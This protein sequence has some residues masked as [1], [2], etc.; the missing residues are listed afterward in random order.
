MKKFWQFS[1]F[2]VVMII[3]IFGIYSS[4]AFAQSRSQNITPI[5]KDNQPVVS[6]SQKVPETDVLAENETIVVSASPMIEVQPSSD[7]LLPVVPVVTPTP[8][9]KL[10]TKSHHG[11]ATGN[12]VV[13]PTPVLTPI[14]QELVTVEIQGMPSYKIILKEND[15]AFSVLLR[16]SLENNFI[17]DYQNYGSWGAFIDCINGICGGQDNKY[18][19][20]YYNGYLSGVGASSQPVSVGDTTTWKFEMPTW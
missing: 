20:F 7:L 18:W 3:I 19:M 12:S 8:I 10:K 9:S 1:W 11:S 6:T 16:A 14:P 15:T 4:S 2:P 5:L 13:T 17:L